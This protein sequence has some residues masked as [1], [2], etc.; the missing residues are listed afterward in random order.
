M[1]EGNTEQNP[2]GSSVVP[3]GFI[4]GDAAGGGD[5]FFDSVAQGMN[6]LCISGGPFDVEVLREACYHYADRNQCSIYDSRSHKTWRQA[7]EDDAVAGK[8][9][10]NS[11]QQKNCFYIYMAN[12][13]L[14]AVESSHLAAAIWGRPEIE[15]RMLCE[16]YGIKLHIIENFH[17]SG[18]DVIG[19]QLVDSSGSRS[20]D[21]HS[22]LYNDPQII[23]ILNE[24]LCHFTPII[25]KTSV[26]NKPIEEEVCTSH[27]NGM[28]SENKPTCGLKLHPVQSVAARQQEV[29][30]SLTQS[31]HRE[32]TPVKTEI[33]SEMNIHQAVDSRYLK[34]CSLTDKSTWSAVAA[35]KEDADF[36]VLKIRNSPTVGAALGFMLQAKFYETFNQT[37]HCFFILIEVADCS[38]FPSKALEYLAEVLD[39]QKSVIIQWDFKDSAECLVFFKQT[40]QS[41]FTP[42]QMNSAG[43]FSTED[44][45]VVDLSKQGSFQLPLL[46]NA[47]KLGIGG[48]FNGDSLDLLNVSFDVKEEIDTWRLIDYAA[49]D[50]DSLSLRFLLLAH[51]DLKQKNGDG[52]RTLEIAA[53]YG[54]PQSLSALLN[55][56]ITNSGEEYFLSNKDKELLELRNDLGDNPFLIAAEKGRPDTL[57]FLIC[58]GADILCHRQGNENVT[59]IKLAWDKKNYGNVRVLLE[60]DSPFP[61]EFD[62]SKNTAVLLRQVEDRQSFHQ[63]IK[64]GSQADVKEFIKIHPRLKLAYDPSNQSALMTALKA[65]QCE[66]YALLQS[67]GFCAGK[68]E[69][70][71][72]VIEALTI[73]ERERLR[74]AKLQYF[75]RHDDSHIIYLLSKSRL[76]FGRGKKKNFGIVRE[77]YKKL[78]TIPEITTVLK[79]VERSALTEI[80]FDFDNDSIIDLDPTK[81]SE[82]K[83]SCYYREG[84]I[85]I[86]AKEQSKLLST[87]AH[88]LTHLA[89]QVCYDNE[90]NP[91]EALDEQKKCAFGKIVAECRDRTGTDEIIKRVFTVYKKES[92]W[93]SELIVRVPHILAHYNEK[94]GKQLLKQQ[95]PELLRF[96]EQ[97]T[98]ED[99]KMFIENPACIK[100]RHEIQHLNTLL[101]NV[102][103]FEQSE[104]WLNDECLLNDVIHCQHIWI[105]SSSLPLLTIFNLYQVLRR[106]GL[107]LSDIKN[108]YIFVSA[109]QFRNQEKSETLYE[110]FQSVTHP[111]LII[112]C[113]H[114]YDTSETDLLSTL[115]S[116]SEKRIIFI[117][118]ADVAQKLQEKLKKY[119]AKM[120]HDRDYTWSDLTTDSQYKLLKNKVCFQGCLVPLNELI[121][122]ESPVT[123]LLPLADLLEKRKLEIGRP[124]LT[125]AADGCIENYYIPRTFNH[126]VAIKK[127][128]FEETF[129]DLV[130]T[131]KKEFIKYCQ[132]N[133]EKNVHWLQKDKSGRLIW[134][135]SQGS[136]NALHEYIDTRNPRPYPPENIDKFLQKAQRQKVMLIADAAGMGKTTVLNH[137]S[138]QIKQK[139]Q[140]YWVVRIDLNDHAEVLE[141]QM[142]QKIGT[143]GFLCEK[144]LKFRDPFEKE[145]FKQCCQ[146]LEEATKVVLML[147][148]FDEISPKY[149]E[150]VLH[151]L[152]D[153]NPLKQTWIEQLWVTTRPHLR[154]ELED[155]LQQLCYTLEPFSEENQV[156][157]LTK[158][159]HQHS[160]LEDESP[161]YSVKYAR[162]LIESLA[163]S[164][165]DKEKVF[166]GIPLQT[167]ILAEAFEK[168]VESYCLSQKSELNVHK[169]LCLVDL[170][171]KFIKE[172]MNIFKS[173]GELA[174]QQDND[175]ILSDI[176]ITKNHQK[177]A[178]EVLLPELRGTA[179]EL[180]ECDTLAREAIS[181]IGIVQYVDNKPHFIHRTFAEY[182]VADFLAT[183]LTKETSFL[184]EVLNIMFEL[185][186]GE[187]YEVTTLFLDGLLA[188]LEKSKAI[189][190]YGKQ[191]YKI[192]NV[193][194]KFILFKIKRKKLTREKLQTA[195]FVAAAKGS[196]N[197]INFFFGSLKAT[198]NTKTIKKILLNKV[199]GKITSYV[200]ARRGHLKRLALRMW[201]REEK[202]KFKDDLLL[203]TGYDGIISRKTETTYITIW[204][205]ASTKGNKE[206]L[207]TLWSWG[208]EVQI[209]LKHD[210]LLAKGY[211]GLTAWDRAEMYGPE[212]ILETLWG[213][214][215]EV[216][217]NLKDNMLLAKGYD[218]V[219]A[220]DK[221]TRNFK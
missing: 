129:S 135:Q 206:I 112:D 2:R 218:G 46:F 4:R 193:K 210:L 53:E 220:W 60:A 140:N 208:T 38:K 37:S 216:E 85:Y 167:R 83:G 12:I 18:Q 142:N 192:W 185:L 102:D 149:K 70:L 68:N 202:V 169:Q 6:E 95:V 174:K 65:R 3:N 156:W 41:A 90:C 96:Y 11:R 43:L 92:D 194:E 161:Q 204:D 212:E 106:N 87:L 81:S 146:G 126:Q 17:S 75:G 79:V 32:Q 162:A 84:R 1:T 93:P 117:A 127:E 8:Y 189:E 61:D 86:G 24:G 62:L 148:G 136:L 125:S 198:G 145:L 154:E 88:E 55:L 16:I 170:Y 100:A 49:R 147:D 73:E 134:Q 203:A 80:I 221:A 54:G 111:T 195:L 122:V 165:S 153:L 101:G 160:N 141:A 190:L 97:Q 15:G 98:Q 166:T 22:S 215:R 27:S 119:Q 48:Q 99:L 209:N 128:I 103:E 56:P 132:D 66:I 110:A 58:C 159:W 9:A 74:Q 59:A 214:G 64:N 120:T 13:G 57:Q 186:L 219:S 150:I 187:G 138:K 47:L 144:L 155:N 42:L 152:Q 35:K 168:E 30:L 200:P 137:L 175:I 157:F 178:L 207:E 177:L 91:Y 188:N 51:W 69:E 25:C 21:E 199:S 183:H 71:S 94:I 123:K 143:L 172:K 28:Q 182:Y 104:I 45:L 115:N 5:C 23:H 33:A 7:I 158:F 52:R 108:D 20:V 131:N 213:W 113:S 36:K 109:E 164:I 217:V 44:E 116:F 176:S 76:G 19:H 114:Q 14:T 63:A 173:K 72:V 179:L 121:S 105:L 107:S 89:M 151:L 133:P 40:G 130:A 31:E 163:Q 77:L 191:I 124:L 196:T 184:L 78:D 26:P 118:F 10:T 181:R 29:S 34:A 205:I 139:F 201:G 50:D 197:I 82:T 67:E 180:E 39:E 211:D 171:R